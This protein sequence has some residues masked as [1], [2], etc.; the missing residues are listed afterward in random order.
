M[1]LPACVFVSLGVLGVFDVK[2]GACAARAVCKDPGLWWAFLPSKHR[3]VLSFQRQG[4]TSQPHT[5]MS[6]VLTALSF[7]TCHCSGG[8]ES[9]RR[10]SLDTCRR[11][12]HIRLVYHNSVGSLCVELGTD[13][14]MVPMDTCSR[15]GTP[16]TLLVGRTRSS[17]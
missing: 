15:R 4:G 12:Y 6:S 10:Y 7:L 8:E 3:S 1:D 16:R 13:C 11:V 9:L 5:A 14:A 17:P 2:C